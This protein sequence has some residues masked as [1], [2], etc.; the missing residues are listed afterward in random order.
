MAS[1]NSENRLS[2]DS[3][4][5]ILAKVMNNEISKF[6]LL[7]YGRLLEV[8]DAKLANIELGLGKLYLQQKILE[9]LLLN[10]NDD[11]LGQKY[12]SLLTS[13][14]KLLKMRLEKSTHDLFLFC[15]VPGCRE[16]YKELLCQT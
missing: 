8:E 9:L 2:Q 4:K 12:D 14:S 1:S 7:Y 16:V 15:E 5:D 13:T 6:N 3:L 11:V 10:Q